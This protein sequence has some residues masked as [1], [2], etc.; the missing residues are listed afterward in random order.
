MQNLI[1]EK[2]KDLCTKGLSKEQIL[3]D[4][5]L[6]CLRKKTAYQK[7]NIEEI[8]NNFV[9][10]WAFKNKYNID[11]FINKLNAIDQTSW[12]NY[13]TEDEAGRK[14]VFGHLGL[15]N[16]EDPESNI[17]VK[18]FKNLALIK[19]FSILYVNDGILHKELGENPKDRIIKFLNLLK[20]ELNNIAEL[21]QEFPEND[22]R[23]S[24]LRSEF[25]N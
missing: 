18:A 2:V 12:C 11:Y 7:E 24:T 19:T 16:N 8:Y 10:I 1:P 13:V 25:N 20:K 22:I 23:W 17:E 15:K 3:S 14:N 9:W 4:D 6:E 5:K 21:N